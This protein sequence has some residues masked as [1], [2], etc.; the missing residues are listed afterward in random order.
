M[1]VGIDVSLLSPSLSQK[2]VNKTI[3]KFEKKVFRNSIVK[4]LF[5]SMEVNGRR[6]RSSSRKK[7]SLF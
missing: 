3:Y 6:D 2:E 7:Q 1:Y 5:R 4:K